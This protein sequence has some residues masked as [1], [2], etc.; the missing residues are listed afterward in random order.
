MKVFLFSL[1]FFLYA[2]P[3]NLKAQALDSTEHLPS[4]W[5]HHWP[6]KGKLT[7]HGYLDFIYAAGFHDPNRSST[8]DFG[9]RQ[10]TSSPLFSDKF[11][12]PYAYLGATYELNRLTLRLALHSGDIV[13]SLYAQEQESMRM[14]REASINY[15][16]TSRF[17]VEAGV[18]PS[19]YGFEIFLSKENIHATR[20]YIADFAPDYES[21]VRF[22]YQVT[23]HWSARLM[24][25][26]GWQ[27]IKDS[28]GKKALGLLAQYDNRINQFFN[29]GIY[30]GD[31][32][33]IGESVSRY[34]MYHNIFWKYV[35]GKWTYVPMLDLAYQQQSDVDQKSLFMIAP[36]FSIR[37]SFNDDWAV[38]SRWD[39]VNDPKNMIPEL[40]GKL[41][42]PSL[43][44]ASNNP[45]GWQSNSVTLTVE[46]TFS[47]N[48]KIRAESRYA[49]NKDAVFIDGPD[50]L[51]DYDGYV[52]LSMAANF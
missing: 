12:L 11:T 19:L 47:D 24:V 45:S 36:A 13:E 5:G 41:V 1:S 30:L 18:F 22:K 52:L 29:W 27:E 37:Y 15:Q 26:N 31:V 34:R 25:L 44:N 3:K 6:R 17:S 49:I 10:Y 7:L 9:R 48:F 32:R 8:T 33:E 51:V 42:T 4:N 40:N 21:G 50:R 16:F 28:N 38:A 23:D 39:M 43:I 14:V 46:R 20:A 2:I 35:H